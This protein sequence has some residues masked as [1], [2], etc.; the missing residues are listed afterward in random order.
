[1]VVLNVLVVCTSVTNETTSH[2]AAYCKHE[3]VVQVVPVSDVLVGENPN[4]DT[5]VA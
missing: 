1:M 2:I 4:L 3:D 5:F